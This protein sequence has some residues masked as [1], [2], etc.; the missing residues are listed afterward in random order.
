MNRE[1][2]DA[3]SKRHEDL[4]HKIVKN[5]EASVDELL[6]ASF[7]GWPPRGLDIVHENPQR[8][9]VTTSLPDFHVCVYGAEAPQQPM[10][11]DEQSPFG[12]SSTIEQRAI[13]INEKRLAECAFSQAS[14]L[15]HETAHILQG[16]HF[17]RARDIMGR[18]GVEQRLS[19]GHSF[20]DIVVYQTI[21]G[22]LDT[23]HLRK[24]FNDNAKYDAMLSYHSQGSEI[25]ARL[26]Q[27][28]MA[29]HDVWGHLPQN[30]DE[31]FFCM[32]SVG[33][34]LPDTVKIVLDTHPDRRKLEKIFPPAPGASSPGYSFVNEIKFLILNLT[35][36]GKDDFWTEAMPRLYADLIEMYGDKSGRERM[37]LGTNET[38]LLRRRHE[39]D[40]AFIGAMKWRHIHNDA[41]E[42]AFTVLVGSLTREQRERII[43]TLDNQYIKPVIRTEDG[44]TWVW[45]RD[46]ESVRELKFCTAAS[47]ELNKVSPQPG[48]R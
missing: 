16:N 47:M 10:V 7:G 9:T 3:L 17:W 42:P 8:V 19:A 39:A 41:L 11:D 40:I 37:G 31:F 25:Q 23:G 33:F 4:A 43:K 12:R 5:G 6:H 13:H 1:K 29:G 44:T 28:L 20:S 15:G 14:T 48:L 46:P 21:K 2:K 18:A 22:R 32:D 24:I 38:H 30:R 27:I 36:R 34:D 26:H 45:V 35:K